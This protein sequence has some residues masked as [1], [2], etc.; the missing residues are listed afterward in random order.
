MAQHYTHQAEMK[1]QGF[2][3]NKVLTQLV[4]ANVD[5]ASWI[6]HT[7]VIS[8]TF[9]G[10]DDDDDDVWQVQ[11]QH[12]PSVTYKIIAPFTKYANCTC[13]CAL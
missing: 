5:K 11:S 1:M 6:P 4:V 12:H 10:D 3:K 2:I 8:P 9:E 7:N 13:E